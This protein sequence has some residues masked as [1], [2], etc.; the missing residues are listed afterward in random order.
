MRARFAVL[1]VVTIVAVGPVIPSGAAPAVI[2]RTARIVIRNFAY[3]PPTLLVRSNQTVR[4]RNEDGAGHTVT[5]N[6]SAF[7]VTVSG[8]GRAHFVAPRRPGRYAYHC[9]F[10]GNMTGVLL[11][12]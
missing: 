10:H 5:A 3:H 8:G 6:N 4:V 2:D 1:L 12:G 7:N 9:T 11:V